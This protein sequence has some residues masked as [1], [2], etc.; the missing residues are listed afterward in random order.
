MQLY[1]FK[2]LASLLI[3][4]CVIASYVV[5]SWGVGD[6]YGYKVRYALDDWQT[7][8]ELPLLGQVNSALANVDEAL[9][10]EGS[11]PE[12]IELKG[13][14]LYYRALVN[15]LDKDSLSDLREAKKLHLR[16]IE[17]R[18]NWPYSWANLVLMKSYLKE[19]DD[20]Y[21]KAL[22]RA[23]RYGPW[24]Q[25]VHLTLSHAA[26]LSWVSLSLEQKHVFAKNVE[27]A[28]VRNSNNIRATLDAYKKRAAICA[29]L[30]RDA[31]QA[32]LCSAA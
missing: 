10:W 13:R 3:A 31:L 9:S 7:Q 4:L 8:E 15:G 23:V 32:T 20:D 19:F 5:I 22:S 1:I 25:S 18:P 28:L 30:K 26:A 24:E 11:N 14:L 29:Y 6:M 12:Y 2:L 27:R 17:L 16:A 21:D